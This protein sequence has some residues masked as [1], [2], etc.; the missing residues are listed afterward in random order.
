MQEKVLFPVSFATAITHSIGLFQK[1]VRYPTNRVIRPV[2]GMFQTGSLLLSIPIT[3]STLC[4]TLCAPQ[5]LF[6]KKPTLS[7]TI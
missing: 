1:D 4:P 6:G 5:G 3:T 7:S 2:I